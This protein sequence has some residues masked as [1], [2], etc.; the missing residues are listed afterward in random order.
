MGRV[1]LIILSLAITIF[2]VADCA[3]TPSEELP[4]KL[5]KALWLL[6]IIL[7]TPVGGIAWLIISRVT[8]AEARGGKV[9]RS[10]WYSETSALDFTPTPNEPVDAPDNDREFLW[11]L[12][13]DI[14]MRKRRRSE[15]DADK[16]DADEPDADDPDAGDPD[17]GEPYGGSDSSR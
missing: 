10:L 6:A 7:I 1:V 5:P 8:Q 9:N 17:A 15:P 12:E 2:S 16:P 13:R 3:R 14:Q 11:R 4:A